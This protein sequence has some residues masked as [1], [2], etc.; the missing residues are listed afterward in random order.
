MDHETSGDFPVS[1]KLCREV[2]A[3]PIF[4]QMTEEDVE[5]VIDEVLDFH[6]HKG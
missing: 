5:R 4:P 2:L 1:E 6:G 3:L